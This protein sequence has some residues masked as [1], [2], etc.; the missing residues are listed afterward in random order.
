MKKMKN[1]KIRKTGFGFV[2]LFAII[3]NSLIFAVTGFSVSP[4]TLVNTLDSA[5]SNVFV[6]INNG[7]TSTLSAN[8][9]ITNLTS[10]NNLIFSHQNAPLEKSL[11]SFPSASS[12]LIFIRMFPP[13]SLYIY[14]YVS[15]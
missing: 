9:I 8:V 10:F 13:L 14:I 4:D 2:I 6:L 12:H 7:A 11:Y 5:P 1:T 15:P 3:L